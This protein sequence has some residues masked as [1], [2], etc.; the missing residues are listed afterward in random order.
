MREV[1]AKHELRAKKSL[2]QNFLLDLNLTRR[3]ARAGGDLTQGTTIEIGPGPGGLTRALLLEG[4]AHVIALEADS[5]AIAALDSLMVAAEGKLDLHQTDALSV[6]CTTLGTA[7]RRIVANLPYNI[8]TPLLLRW[9]AQAEAFE[10][11]TVMLQSEVVDRLAAAPG[12]KTFGRLSVM[13]QWRCHV[14]PLFTVPASAFTPAPKVE[15]R[16]VQLRPRPA[17]LAPCDP[18]TLE[19]V[20][21]AAFGQRRKMLRASLKS[22]GDSQALCAEAGIDP[23]ARAETLSVEQFCALARLVDGET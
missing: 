9:I 18:R 12:S 8:A 11:V 2:G 16:I 19:Q 22:L 20:T 21:A 10:S 3:I 13:A 14:E 5:R 23:T 17:P 15:S 6:D 4:A 7:P 1:I